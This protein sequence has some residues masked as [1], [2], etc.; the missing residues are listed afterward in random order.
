MPINRQLIVI[1]VVV[2]GG[3]S[4]T[5]MLYDNADWLAQRWASGLVDA[6]EVQNAAW[7]EPFRLA[8]AEHR[9]EI[10]PGMV[11]LLRQLEVE[12]DQ[13]SDA[14]RLQCLAAAADRI[15]R[16]HAMLAVRLGTRVLSDLSP[17]QI[18]HLETELRG[19]NRDYRDDYLDPD[20]AQRERQRVARYLERIERW[21]GDLTTEQI[22]LV[23]RAV[24]DLPDLADD[25]LAYRE[26]QQRRLLARLRGAPDPMAL[27]RFLA[28]WWVEL[29]DRPPALVQKTQQVRSGITG[30]LVALHAMLAAEQRAEFLDNVRGLREDL[31]NAAGT[32]RPLQPVRWD[33]AA[34]DRAGRSPR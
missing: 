12:I 29:G 17:Q 32:A 24:R 4:R 16:Q 27:Q 8:M 3:C 7:R 15:F 11:V 30:L 9:R 6:S 20:P 5:G 14:D 19:R 18:A 23:E 34:C 28:A 22:R 25:W 26:Q 33:S 31:D 10:L 21:T 2:L 13:G 1:F